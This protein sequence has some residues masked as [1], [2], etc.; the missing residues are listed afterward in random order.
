[1]KNPVTLAEIERQF[2]EN[3]ENKNGLGATC[4]LE[5]DGS[6]TSV[7]LEFVDG[8]IVDQRGFKGFKSDLEALNFATKKMEEITAALIE[9]GIIN[10]VE[11]NFQ[12]TEQNSAEGVI[13]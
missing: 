7:L 4:V 12:I 6:F 5:D 3:M 9:E 11:V 8:K 1:M 13:H 10:N 2:T